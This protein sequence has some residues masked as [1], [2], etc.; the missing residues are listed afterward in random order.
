MIPRCDRVIYELWKLPFEEIVFIG[1]WT[2]IGHRPSIPPYPPTPTPTKSQH[3][4]FFLHVVHV[5][6]Y[7]IRILS[8][9]CLGRGEGGVIW[10]FL[11]IL[12]KYFLIKQW[13]YSVFVQNFISVGRVY[14]YLI[15]FYKKKIHNMIVAHVQA[16]VREENRF[17]VDENTFIE[18]DAAWSIDGLIYLIIPEID[19]FVIPLLFGQ[20]QVTRNCVFLNSLELY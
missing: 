9:L 6:T 7:D 1:A 5:M 17:F 19:T 13:T 15:L 12:Q 20:I 8:W 18:S 10:A 16:T 4:A 11:I 2:H 14:M 3:V